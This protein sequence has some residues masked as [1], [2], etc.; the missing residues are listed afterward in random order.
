MK[1]FNYTMREI[2]RESFGLVFVCLFVFR[3]GHI[4]TT[5]ERERERVGLV[6]V[7]LFLERDI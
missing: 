7:C 3:T 5:R 4:K 1:R 6:F 2:E